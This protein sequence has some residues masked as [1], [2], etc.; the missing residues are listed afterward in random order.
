MARILFINSV[1]NGSTGTICKNLYKLAEKA[2]HECCIAYGRGSSLQG[3]NTVKI[4]SDRDVYT[5]VIKARVFDASGEGSKSVTRKFMSW[6]DEYQPDIIH[7][8]NLHGYYLNIK[9]FF[10]YLKKHPEIKKIWTLHDC[11]AYTGHCAYY[12]YVKCEKWKSRCEKCPAANAYPKTYIDQSKKNYGSKKLIF[13]GVKNL[14]IVTPSIWLQQE[15]RYSYL[16][17]YPALTINNGIDISIFKRT[18]SNLKEK[19]GIGDKKIILG[20]ASVWDQRKGLDS[21]IE[22]SD[23]LSSDYK[24]VLIGLNEKQ[25]KTLPANIIGIKR[26]ENVEELVKWYSSA[27]ILFNPTLEDNYPTVNLEAQACGTF[28]IAYDA[29]GTKETIKNNNGRIVY[30]V[31]ELLEFLE[32]NHIEKKQE[33]EKDEYD[34][35][36]CFKSYINLYNEG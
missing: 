21:F 9:I 6:I 15:L 29:G 35:K 5:H 17:E 13:T 11:W 2:G 36:Y 22:L 27:H 16:K 30:S 28:V 20:V 4:G 1:C 3:F 23:K 14:I 12:T 19:Y 24:I 34:W 33:I 10:E 31:N 25:I 8:H 32:K 26:T 18:D 7:M